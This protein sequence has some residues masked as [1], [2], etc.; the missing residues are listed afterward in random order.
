VNNFLLFFA[1]GM[2]LPSVQQQSASTLELYLLF[3]AIYFLFCFSC[4]P[5]TYK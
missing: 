1:R 4:I 5:D 2:S 3:C